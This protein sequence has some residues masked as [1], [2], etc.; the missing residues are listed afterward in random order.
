[1]TK[2]LRENITERAHSWH[3]LSIRIYQPKIFKTTKAANQLI[4]NHCSYD[5]RHCR[6]SF[7]PSPEMRLFTFSTT[8]DGHAI[9]IEYKE[10][11]SFKFRPHEII[12]PKIVEIMCKK[13]LKLKIKTGKK[14]YWKQ[15]SKT[16]VN[17]YMKK[18][19][20]IE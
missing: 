4:Q 5:Y 13:K 8:T 16:C 12:S 3:I 1:M 9:L 15:M 18:K 17:L 11:N 10:P 20:I 7:L 2:C 6:F 19:Q 14:N